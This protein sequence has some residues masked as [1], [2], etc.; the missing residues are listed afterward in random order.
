M[1]T[2]RLVI[3]G[4][5]IMAPD[6]KHGIVREEAPTIRLALEPNERAQRILSDDPK[7]G[8]GQKDAPSVRLA[9]AGRGLRGTDSNL[10]Y[11]DAPVVG[12]AHSP[13]AQGDNVLKGRHGVDPIPQDRAPAILVS[14]YYIEKFLP[15]QSRYIYRDWALD[16][17][18][19]SAFNSGKVIDLQK[20][21]DFCKERREQDPTLRDIFSL[22]VIGDWKQSLIN[23]EEMW[24]QGVEAIPCFHAGEPWEALKAMAAD[25]PKIGIGGVALARGNRKLRWAEQCFARV[26]PKKIHGFAYCTEEAL[27]R[28]PFHSV[29]STNWELGPCRFGRWKSFG[30]AALRIRGSKQ[31]LRSEVEYYLRIEE[32]ARVRWKREMAQLEAQ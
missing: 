8:I 12:L 24:K 9:L 22:D 23:T 20:Y 1:T 4:P 17:G 32:Q 14:Y 15:S 6:P 31:N 21:I 2:L 29:D 13:G 25:Y 30:N 5:V 11:A 28:V 7:H 27:M 18:A 19:F 16:S 10:L 26:W 3:A